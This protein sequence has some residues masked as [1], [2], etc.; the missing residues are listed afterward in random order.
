[1][2]VGAGRMGK[3]LAKSLTGLGMTVAVNDSDQRRGRKIAKTLNI[4]FKELPTS[5]E[6][7][8][9]IVSVPVEKTVD[10]CKDLAKRMK[11]GSLLVDISSVKVGVADKV[12]S[13]LPD[14]LEYISIHP[15]FGPSVR[16]VRGKNFVVVPVRSERWLSKFE[17]ILRDLSGR[18]VVTGIQQHD[19]MMS[20]VQVLHHFAYLCLATCLSRSEL[21]EEFATESFMETLR[22][23]RR[24]GRN[25]DVILSIQR[26]NPLAPIAREQFSRVVEELARSNPEELRR[27][28]REAF[29]SPV[30]A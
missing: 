30:L 28:A 11:M 19:R 27:T 9:V 7:E 18:V 21:K 13:S 16:S 23:L 20:T 25:L 17:K 8:I 22:L 1:L 2:I 4:R 29:R 15:L 14:G 3:L 24:I 10:V 6:E 26:D 12:S 5:I